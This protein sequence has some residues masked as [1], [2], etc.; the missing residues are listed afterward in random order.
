LYFLQFRSCLDAILNN[1]S[2]KSI[3]VH[4]YSEILLRV[5]LINRKIIET[6]LKTQVYFLQQI[7]YLIIKLSFLGGFYGF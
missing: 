4:L 5:I 7:L 3:D 2:V 6:Q 1:E